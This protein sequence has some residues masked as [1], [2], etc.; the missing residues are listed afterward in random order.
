[1]LLRRILVAVTANCLRFFNLWSR[2]EG[3]TLSFSLVTS[4][5]SHVTSP[6]LFS[7]AALGYETCSRMTP[8]IRVISLA[9]F[10]PTEKEWLPKGSTLY[11]SLTSLHPLTL[12]SWRSAVLVCATVHSVIAS[13][14]ILFYWWCT[15][16]FSW[17]YQKFKRKSVALALTIDQ[18]SLTFLF[19]DLP[20]TG[21]T[22]SILAAGSAYARSVCDLDSLWL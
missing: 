8:L 13:F 16:S 5:P 12:S 6:T 4:T 10:S 7:L 9:T 3:Q 22:A 17:Y 11:C 14:V 18:K 20:L 21:H 2:R 15:N 19:Q 1:M